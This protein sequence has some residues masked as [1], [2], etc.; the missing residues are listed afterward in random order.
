MK[1]I[2]AV[3]MVCLMVTGVAVSTA[4]SV[5]AATP[6]DEIV[7]AAKTNLPEKLLNDYLPAIENVLKQIDVSEAQS[8]EII[9]CIQETREYFEAT[10]GFTGS[11][12]HE[13]TQEQRKFALEMI[14]RVCDI[15]NLRYEFTPSTNPKH[16]NDMVFIVYNA[17]GQKLGE[18]DGDAV[19]KTNAPDADVSAATSVNYGYAVLAAVLLAG[20]AAAVVVGRKLTADR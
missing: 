11:S 8:A 2:I 14:A 6:E 10:G 4:T 3:L 1:K 20:A 18:F 12:L 17:G 9:L 5:S 16:S 7:T 19:K 13:Y 15:L